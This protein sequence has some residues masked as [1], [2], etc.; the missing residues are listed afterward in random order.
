[1]IDY[2]LAIFESHDY[3]DIGRQKTTLGIDIDTNARRNY[4]KHYDKIK[5]KNSEYYERFENLYY[6]KCAYCGVSTKIN[7]APLYEVDHFINETQKT[8]GKSAVSVDHIS[9]LIFSCRNCNQSKKDFRVNE[10]FDII[11]PDGIKVGNV[12]ERGEHFEIKISQEYISNE[13]INDFYK[14]MEFGFRFRKLD[15]LLLNLYFMKEKYPEKE[16]YQVLFSKLLE[17]RNSV[18][19]L[20]KYG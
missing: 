14:K 19:S 16:S 17:L 13:K 11:H 15:Y 5:D 6:C 20:K 18:P 7:P 3:S 10:I 9:N 8:I 2:R 12:F 4:G 1:M